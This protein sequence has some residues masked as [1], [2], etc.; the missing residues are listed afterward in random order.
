MKNKNLILEQ[1][2][3]Y[4]FDINQYNKKQYVHLVITILSVFIL[5]IGISTW[6]L[7][8]IGYILFIKRIKAKRNLVKL[9]NELIDNLDSIKV[10]LSIDEYFD[11]LK[12]I[13]LAGR[14]RYKI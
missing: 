4:E 2:T 13:K 8:I 12:R 11:C 9:K 10:E 6:I 7:F 14:K 5:V 3:G 1:I